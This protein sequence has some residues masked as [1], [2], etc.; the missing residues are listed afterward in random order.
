MLRLSEVRQVQVELTTRCNAR[1]PMCMRNYRGSDYNS[2]YPLTELTLEQFQHILPPSLLSQ[3]T[4]GVQFN[5]NLGDFGLATDAIRIVDYLTKHQVLVYI[6]TNGSMRTTDWWKS[7]ARHG[8]TIGWALDG[9]D[10]RTHSLYRQDTN[11]HTVIDNA[12]AFISAGGQAI[13]R[14]APF[15]HNRDQEDR[16]RSMAKELGFFSFQN[17]WDGRDQGPV[18]H[19]DGT[20]SHWLGSDNRSQK[21]DPV[22]IKPLLK[23]HV[24][25]FDHRT[26]YSDREPLK[27][28]C[29][30]HRAQEI[31]VAADGSVYPCCYLGFYPASMHHPGNSQIQPLLTENNA[32]MFPLEHCM[33]WFDR[34]QETWS[35]PSIRQGR[36]Y[37]CVKS[38]GCD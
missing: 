18:F 21:N 11:W 30:H 28:D 2:G 27:L 13:W 14:F 12:C 17:I 37:T 33:A 31:Y 9:A 10:A 5:G 22:D 34:V 25:W 6:N 20:F 36:L 4:R 1:C 29:Y 19:R 16:C 23:S 15:D 38:C 26:V 35:K 32:L 3:L 24:T 7:L 8:V